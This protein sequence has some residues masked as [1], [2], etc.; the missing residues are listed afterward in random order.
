MKK[1][2]ELDVLRCPYCGA[3]RKLIAL[4]TDGAVVRKILEH[5]ELPTTTESLAPAR[6]PPELELAW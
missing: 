4:I 6:G 3:K 5:L 1:V 2:F